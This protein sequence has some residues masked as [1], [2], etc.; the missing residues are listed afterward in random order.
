[1]LFRS[2]RQA[3]FLTDFIDAEVPARAPLVIA[4]DFNDW[5]RRVDGVLRSRLGL[6]EVGDAQDQRR[7]YERLLP[8]S[9]LSSPLMPTSLKRN[10]RAS[11]RLPLLARTFP[12]FAP[13]LHLDR[14]YL[15]GCEVTAVQIPRGREWSK[16]SDHMPLIAQVGVR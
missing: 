1:M 3:S 10:S 4:G 15:R 9:V 5:Q 12:S 2:Q 16:R 7:W 11:P 6:I 8:D 13:W 14:I